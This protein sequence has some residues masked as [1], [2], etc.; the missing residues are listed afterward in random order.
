MAT[1]ISMT[2][3][4]QCDSESCVGLYYISCL[5]VILYGDAA[6][7]N[8]PSVRVSQSIVMFSSQRMTPLFSDSVDDVYSDLLARSL[9][10]EEVE[11]A[12][13]EMHF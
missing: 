12:A 8:Q 5:L 9:I 13:S 11:Q 3:W 10:L 6:H 2:V 4:I 1:G 7:C